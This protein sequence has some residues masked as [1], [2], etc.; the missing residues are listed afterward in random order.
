M[1]CPFYPPHHGGTEKYVY[2]LSAIFSESNDVTVITTRDIPTTPSEEVDGKLK[3]LRFEYNMRPLNNPISLSQFKYVIKYSKDIDILHFNDIYA[4]PTYSSLFV[5]RTPK[6]LSFHTW[7]I[8]YENPLK[9]LFTRTFE[10]V[11]FKRIISKMDA[12]IVL[13]DSQ[14][15]YFKKMGIDQNKIFVVPNGI[16]TDFFGRDKDEARKYFNIETDFVIGFF[17]RFFE[18]KGIKVLLDTFKNLKDDLYIFGYGPLKPLI[19]E[20]SNKYQNIHLI[21]GPFSEEEVA[22]I[23]SAMDLNILPSLSGEGCPTGLLEALSS[24]TFCIASDLPENV[25]TLKDKGLYFRRGDSKDLQEKI[26]IAKGISIDKTDLKNYA[27][28]YDWKNISKK[29]MDVYDGV[30]K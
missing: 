14:K 7:R 22:L 6:I 16:Q 23:Y 9:D 25:C 21:G 28:E 10:R 2:N 13:V 29:V 26:K 4:F 27:R 30:I 15:D 19:V 5:K 11:A 24:G 18:R 17:G 20:Y 8:K 1:I 12:L 3:I